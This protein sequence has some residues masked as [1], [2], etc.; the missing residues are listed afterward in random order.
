MYCP[1]CGKKAT[2]DQNFCRGCG[3]EL[4][5]ISELL[6]EQLS[7][8]PAVGPGALDPGDRIMNY[9]AGSGGAIFLGG[10]ALLFAYLIYNIFAKLVID[11][12]QIFLGSALSLLLTGAILLLSYVFYSEVQ[13][14][15]RKRKGPSSPPEIKEATTT[16][17]LTPANPVG[18][19]SSVTEQTTGLLEQEG[20][21]VIK[22]NRSD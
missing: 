9:I 8:T 14:D 6:A 1:N 22:N 12:G 20:V 4:E 11:R 17:K 5:K 21:P 10:G 18:V 19:M 3:L 2:L 16:K 13:K 15:K 7:T